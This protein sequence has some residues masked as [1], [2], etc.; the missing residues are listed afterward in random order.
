MNLNVVL[1][2]PEIPQNTGNIGRLTAANRIN[3]HLIEPMSFK[4]DDKQVKRAG[5]DYWPEVKLTIHPSWNAFLETQNVAVSQMWFFTTKTTTE[6]YDVQFR[7][8]DYLVFGSETKGL[9]YS[10]HEN[11]P[12]RRL[13]IPIENPNV[14]SLNLANAVAIAVFEAR[15]QWRS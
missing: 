8:G 9:D 14:R 1:V 6:Y 11:Y 4:I 2:N 7:E 12:E 3:L 5:L 15:R 10:F 13:K